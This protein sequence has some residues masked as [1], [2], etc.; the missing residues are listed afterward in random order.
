MNA[1]EQDVQKLS[2]AIANCNGSA[3][4]M[5]ETM[6][7]NLSGQITI[8]KSQLQELAI[9]FGDML[10]PLIRTTPTPSFLMPAAKVVKPCMAVPILEIVV[11]WLFLLE[12]CLCPSSAKS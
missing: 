9:S 2:S 12:I 4:S 6:Q 3:V 8:L 10:M 5:A 11:P 1:G 7:D